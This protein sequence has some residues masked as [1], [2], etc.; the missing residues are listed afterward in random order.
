[1]RAR[2]MSLGKA[3]SARGRISPRLV[4]TRP[5]APPILEDDSAEELR[6]APLTRDEAESTSRWRYG[7]DSATYDGTTDGI[8]DMLDP[9]NNYHS[10]RLG[11]EYV[12][13]VCVGADARIADLAAVAG[14]DDIGIGLA[15]TVSA[16][17]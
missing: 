17:G 9:A 10:I 13:Y 2:L 5:L 15:L 3:T 6:L 8:G 1:L 4:R 16:T 7:P 14:A 12:G 11:G